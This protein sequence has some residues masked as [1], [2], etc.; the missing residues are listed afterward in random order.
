MDLLPE[1]MG[2]TNGNGDTYAI[3]ELERCKWN[4]KFK[5]FNN[6]STVS[7]NTMIDF[8]IVAWGA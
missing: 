5:W 1:A 7:A 8:S 4:I 3:M 6:K 2:G